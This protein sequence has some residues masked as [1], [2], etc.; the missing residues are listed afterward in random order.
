MKR[1]MMSTIGDTI[2]VEI[3]AENRSSRPG[4]R[5]RAK[6]Y[7]ASVSSVQRVAT[8]ANATIALFAN[9]RANGAWRMTVRYA[10]IVGWRGRIVGGT[11]AASGLVLNEVVRDHRNGTNMRPATPISR[12]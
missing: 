11:W 2:T 12:P 8:T 6:A 10:S 3:T 5:I 1:G 4:K 9:H 7:P